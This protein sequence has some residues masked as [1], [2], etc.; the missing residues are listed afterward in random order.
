[1]LRTSRNKLPFGV[2]VFA[3]LVAMLSAHLA[4][5]PRAYAELV[6]NW[7][8]DSYAGWSQNGWGT[9]YSYTDGAGDS[10]FSWGWWSDQAIWQNTTATFEADTVYTMTVVARK[11]DA[12]DVGVQLELIDVT[13][14]W[15]LLASQAWDFALTTYGDNAPWELFQLSLDTTLNPGIVGHEIGVA[16][17]NQNGGG[18]GWIH[19]DSVSLVPDGV[20]GTMLVVDPAASQQRLD[21]WGTSL[22]WWANG[23][24]D[25]T[26]AVKRDLLLDLIFDSSFGLGLNYARYHIG[27]GEDPDSTIWFRPGA[28]IPGFQPEPGV[29]DWTADPYQRFVMQEAIARGVERVD[30]FSCSPPWWM[31]ISGS[32]TGAVD[33]GNNLQSTMYDDFA[34]YLAEVTR[35][36]RNTHGIRFEMVSPLNEPMGTWWVYGNWNEGCHFDRPQQNLLIKEF[37]QALLDKH[38]YDT[39]VSAPE[40]IWINTS[41]DSLTSYDSEALSYIGQANTHTYG[42]AN[43][44]GLASWA[45]SA[46]VPL[47]MSEYGDGTDSNFEAMFVTAQQIALDVN[48]MRV[49]CWTA[50]ALVSATSM[51]DAAERWCMI[52]ANFD[53]AEDFTVYTKYYGFKQFT[54]NVA[55]GSMIIDPGSGREYRFLI[56]LHP[57]TGRMAIIAINP[58]DVADELTIDLGNMPF[59]VA[60]ADRIRTSATQN[61]SILTP[62]TVSSGLLIDTLPA[63]SITSYTMDTMPNP[64]QRWL[65]T[66]E[67]EGWSTNG[68]EMLETPADSG[69]HVRTLNLA[70]PPVSPE[71]W[72]VQH[73]VLPALSYPA[74]TIHA[75]YKHPSATLIDLYFDDNVHG[76]GWLPNDNLLYQDPPYVADTYV[77]VGTFQSEI[78]DAGDWDAG[79]SQTVMRDDGQGGDAVASDGIY[80]LRLAIPAAGT[81]SMITLADRSWSTRI[82]AIGPIGDPDNSLDFEIEFPGQMVTFHCDVNLNR[83]KAAPRPTGNWPG[84][85]AALGGPNVLP[86]AEAPL[87]PQ[88]ILDLYDVDDDNDVDLAD[89]A[90]YFA[91]P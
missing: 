42:G 66:T 34:D 12:D 61:Y 11:G 80:T 83:I 63:K 20:A 47:F 41:L 82:T 29:W 64:A 26:N 18:S 78:G 31:T 22:S 57:T 65:A 62:L 50:W 49:P 74:S 39:K 4:A 85:I 55:P 77:V 16:V 71:S 1:M 43:R 21:Y 10:I 8:C 7:D 84:L 27:G 45:E 75:W 76:D 90:V 25:W 15:A 37:G 19:V 6:N 14:G 79:S 87:T 51:G 38:A 24:G 32:V 52:L 88:D 44:A 46:G 3:A 40:E 54:A 48:V 35:F 53:G 68:A 2:P 91:L 17:R 36:Y 67:A 60:S 58:Y 23:I 89:V 73:V 33:G 69:S 5:A 9:Y 30:A 86:P 59:P 56:G 28:D 70:A 13:D 72:H 81:Y